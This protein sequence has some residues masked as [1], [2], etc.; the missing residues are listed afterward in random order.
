EEVLLRQAL[1][2][3][4]EQDD[5][6]VRRRLLQKVR[7]FIENSRPLSEPGEAQ[8]QQF[9]R[10]EQ[11]RYLRP[12]RLSFSHYYFSSDQRPEARADAQQALRQLLQNH[13]TEKSSD[14]TIGD[15][16]MLAPAMRGQTPA[17]IAAL[18]GH[19]FSQ[20]LIGL[21]PG[22]WQGPIASTYGWHLVYI[23]QHQASAPLSFAEAKTE[24]LKD[25]RQAQNRAYA[26]AQLS[27]LKAAYKIQIE[28]AGQDKQ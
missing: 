7:F 3:G 18:F 20:Q 19:G 15:P 12:A 13:N 14:N 11:Q 25:W 5:V 4:L 28:S 6:I 1:A 16:F 22:S 21:E 8:L 10:A 2:L 17:D 24:L 27:Q 26:K 23:Q 9:Y